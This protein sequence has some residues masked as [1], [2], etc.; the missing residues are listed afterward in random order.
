MN[1]CSAFPLFFGALPFSGSETQLEK[2]FFCGVSGNIAMAIYKATFVFKDNVNNVGWTESWWS[3][4]ADI[5]AAASAWLAAATPRLTL[6]EDTC[7][8]QAVRV[9]NVDHPRDSKVEIPSPNVG[10]VSHSSHPACGPWDALLV[11]RDN[12]LWNVFGKIFMHGIQQDLFVGRDVAVGTAPATAFLASLSSYG[13]NLGLIPALLRKVVGGVATYPAFT[14][15]RAIRRTEHRVGR[16][17][18]GLRGRRAV[19]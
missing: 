17:F 19:A 13:T 1:T 14:D 18:D 16:P 15:F 3:N 8:M 5:Y 7:I 9:S 12:I 10:G 6:L 11:R 2:G 4:H